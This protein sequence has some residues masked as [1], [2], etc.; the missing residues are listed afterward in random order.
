MPKSNDDLLHEIKSLRSEVQ[1][2]RE[3]V[4]SLVNIVMEYEEM[5][6]EME[7]PVRPPQDNFSLHN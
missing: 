7:L 4:N 6:D 3:I 1:Q 2:L 5:D